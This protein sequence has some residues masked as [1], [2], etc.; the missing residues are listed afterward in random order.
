MSNDIV[1]YVKDIAVLAPLKM[2]VQ[3]LIDY[4]LEIT[5]QNRTAYYL[6]VAEL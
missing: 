6:K 3:I 2:K 4:Y 5:F 1:C